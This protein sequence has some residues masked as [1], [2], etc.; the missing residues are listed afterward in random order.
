[1]ENIYKVKVSKETTQEWSDHFYI[2]TSRPL[3][4]VDGIIQDMDEHELEEFLGDKMVHE[5][6]EDFV[7][8]DVET[9]IGDIEENSKIIDW[10]DES[11]DFRKGKFRWNI[12]D[13]LKRLTELRTE[14]QEGWKKSE[15]DFLQI[16]WELRKWY[17]LIKWE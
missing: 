4:E 15:K 6:M 7:T 2:R 12:E 16:L 11:N 3:V 17:L 8:G 10:G 14:K 9:F 5:N 13:V 1:M